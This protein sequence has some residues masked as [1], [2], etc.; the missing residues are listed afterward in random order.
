VTLCLNNNIQ[1]SLGNKPFYVAIA[2]RTSISKSYRRESGRDLS[3]L[4][5]NYTMGW[6]G[7]CDDSKNERKRERK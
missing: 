3:P 5:E 2:C 7:A 6:F 4:T 1:C